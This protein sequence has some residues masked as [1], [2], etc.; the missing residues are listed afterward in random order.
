M[1][2]L[3]VNALIVQDFVSGEFARIN[4]K[5]TSEIFIDEDSNEFTPEQLKRLNYRLMNTRHTLHSDKINS[6]LKEIKV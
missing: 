5:V 6:I 4:W 2:R 1:K 3:L